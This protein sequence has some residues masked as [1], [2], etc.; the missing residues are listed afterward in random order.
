MG[1]LVVC[2]ED[3]VKTLDVKKDKFFVV[4]KIKCFKAFQAL[5]ESGDFK[6]LFGHHDRKIMC[7]ILNSNKADVVQYANLKDNHISGK[8][9]RKTVPQDLLHH[10][11]C[12]SKRDSNVDALKAVQ[13][14]CHL[15]CFRSEDATS[16]KRICEWSRTG[17]EGFMTE[18]VR[19]EH[20]ETKDSD[21]SGNALRLSKGLRC[22]L[23]NNLLRKLG[24]CSEEFLEKY[25]PLVGTNELSLKELADK[26]KDEQ[27][28]LVVCKVLSKIAD[29]T[30]VA[31]LRVR[32]SGR[33]EDDNLKN[34]IGAVYDDNFMNQ[35][36]IDLKRYYDFVTSM[37]EDTTDHYNSPID[38]LI[39]DEKKSF[40]NYDVLETSNLII[41]NMKTLHQ[42]EVQSI[43]DSIVQDDKTFNAGLLLFPQE[44]DYFHVRSF[45]TS[46]L[47]QFSSICGNFQILPLLFIKE[48]QLKSSSNLIEENVQHGILFGKFVVIKP[49]LLVHYA[50][51]SQ[52]TKVVE[53][54][55]SDGQCVTYVSDPGLAIHRIHNQSLKWSVRYCGNQ[56]DIKK[57]QKQLAVDNKSIIE[58]EAMKDGDCEVICDDE[59]TASTLATTSPV[60][61]IKKPQSLVTPLKGQDLS[62]SSI[63]DSGFIEQ[64][65]VCPTQNLTSDVT[66]VAKFLDFS[67]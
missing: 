46:S 6:K 55:C 29:H 9:G 38:F 37:A 64:P 31:V 3:D 60:A 32:H 15:C 54:I 63:N 12:L 11:K 49:P 35:R 48:Q 52:I 44:N 41:Y 51:L 7:Y 47:D 28:N 34:F 24:K 61:P 14:M 1:V 40:I 10:F 22:N 4:Q 39:M 21:N 17:F 20:Y 26:F 50:S 59:Y 25:L 8:F 57:F 62:L 18:L 2:P 65:S 43:M 42:T 33:F 27:Y 56:S 58:V 23:P 13:R 45:L 66:P 67:F 5:D 36:A 53:A 16:V 19:Y 30:S